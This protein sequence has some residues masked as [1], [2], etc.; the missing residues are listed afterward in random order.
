V[1]NPTTFGRYTIERHLAYGGMAE[2]LLGHVTGPEGFAKRVVIKRI[3]PHRSTDERYVQMF[4]DEARIAARFNHPNLVQ[5]YELA[6]VERQYCMVMEYIEGQDLDGILAVCAK[7][8]QHMGYDIASFVVAEAAAGLHYAHELCNDAG[9]PLNLVHRDVSPSNIIVTWQGGIKVVDFGIAKH[10]ESSTHTQ[11]GVLKGKLSYMSPEQALGKKVDRRSDLFSL[12]SVLYELVTSVCCFDRGRS[13]DTLD[14]VVSAVYRPARDYRPDIPRALERILQRM[15]AH[16]PDDRF[17]TALDVARE[18]QRFLLETH[19]SVGDE[20][21]QFMSSLFDRATSMPTRGYTAVSSEPIGDEDAGKSLP[22][23]DA[24]KSPKRDAQPGA[25]AAIGAFYDDTETRPAVVDSESLLDLPTPALFVHDLVTPQVD[26]PTL[27]QALAAEATVKQAYSDI[28]A[29]DGARGSE[30]EPTRRA[31]PPAGDQTLREQPLPTPIT[32]SAERP[33]VR[34]AP[35]VEPLRPLV[36]A[37]LSPLPRPPRR[38]ALQRSAEILGNATYVV[39]RATKRRPQLL[40]PAIGFIGALLL[41]PVV[42]WFVIRP[43]SMPTSALDA[44]LTAR[45]RDGGRGTLVVEPPPGL[46]SVDATV[47]AG[48]AVD[49]TSLVASPSNPYDFRE[50]PEPGAEDP[51]GRQ[52]RPRKRLGVLSLTTDPPVEALIDGRRLGLT[53]LRDVS[54]SAGNHTLVLR[55]NRNGISRT[56]PF[57]IRSGERATRELVFKKGKVVVDVKPWAEVYWHGRKLGLTPMPPFELY[58]G[59]HELKLRNPDLGVERTVSITV[60][61]GEVTKVVERF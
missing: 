55:D 17:A 43:A 15:L 38:S 27:R 26:E 11:T 48:A 1:E 35:P 60:R 4:L 6:E 47:D 54:L 49:A 58:E 20:I 2:V 24:G 30:S 57:S 22:R 16:R 34:A 13:F 23:E 59:T 53:P 40:G 19:L 8:R 9:E 45:A 44:A 21:K 10:K 51:T 31:R 33:T 7:R 14:A 41:L 36:A 61:P 28:L 56:V 50:E 42:Y 18:L 3:L 12:G 29:K 39:R 52:P 37:P 25:A 32:G 5:I 46:R